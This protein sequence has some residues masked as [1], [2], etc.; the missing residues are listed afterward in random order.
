MRVV[1]LIHTEGIYGAELILVYLAREMQ[2][3][4][5]EMIIGSI[6]D[7]GV[8]ASEFERF[9][10]GCG[11]T[12]LPIRIP[13]RPTPD[14]V[15][16]LLRIVK[17]ARA[18]I[19]HSHG[20]KAD[21]LL[22]L[23][24]RSLRGPM[25][26]TA[27]GWTYPP[28]FTMLWLYQAVDRLCLRR[29]DKVV[30]VADHMLAVE[31]VRSLPA[32]KS[33]VIRNG[34]PS[35]QERLADQALRGI[36]AIPDALTQFVRSRPTLVAIGRLSLEKGFNV[37]LDAFAV[38]G[39]DGPAWQLAIIGEGPQRQALEAQVSQLGLSDRVSLPGYVDCADRVLEGAR[40]FVM[41]S[42]TEG[43][44]LALLEA[45]QWRVP[46]V[47]TAVGAIPAL[48]NHGSGGLLVAPRD[49]DALANALRTVMAG[50]KTLAEKT[51]V[52]FATV[53]GEYS[54]TRMSQ[55][56]A[57]LYRSILRASPLKSARRDSS[58]L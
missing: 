35:L 13:P 51:D 28:R 37:L 25:V 40:G 50:E 55:E 52:A 27:H 21:I 5:D 43:L 30:L 12:V 56:Y 18:D 39:R 38:A 16:S 42:F 7:P 20:Y 11:L 41:S 22:G 29:L 44:P 19:L 58:Q 32:G 6:N 15:R 9:A 17:Q 47:A 57:T 31:A 54:S 34:I 10:A 36:Q 14:V 1:H 23:L 26:T 53:T 48:L 8:A 33:V 4:G 24:P 45:M 49:G 46:I 2:R 3:L